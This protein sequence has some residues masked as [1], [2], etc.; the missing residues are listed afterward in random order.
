MKGPPASHPVWRNHARKPP[1]C[2]TALLTSKVDA[3][4]VLT[5]NLMLCKRVWGEPL[6]PFGWWT[7]LPAWM[8]LKKHRQILKCWCCTQ[9]F[10][11]AAQTMDSLTLWRLSIWPNVTY[12]HNLLLLLSYAAEWWPEKQFWCHC[13]VDL[14]PFAQGCHHRILFVW[15][16]VTEVM[17][18]KGIC[19]VRTRN[20]AL[21]VLRRCVQETSCKH[22]VSGCSSSWCG[23]RKKGLDKLIVLDGKRLWHSLNNFPC[24]F[25][26]V[27]D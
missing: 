15:N 16:F 11:P 2:R 3:T 12:G 19:E 9:T 26:A 13:E 25:S 17:T 10:H 18:K 27:C 14:W 4:S 8:W 23:G 22:N 24:C 5:H 20:S 7:M 21:L 6:G 1:C